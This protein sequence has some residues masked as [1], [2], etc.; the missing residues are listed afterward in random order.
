MVYTEIKEKN[1][2]KY[3]YRVKSIRKGNKVNKKRIY[4]GTNLKRKELK[5]KES[6]ADVEL[7]FLNNLLNKEETSFLKKIQRSY[8]NEPHKTIENRYEHF[9]ALFTYNSTAIEGNTFTL[10][11]TAHLLFDNMVPSSKSLREINEILNHKKAFDFLLNY[12]G[13]ISSKIICKLHSLVVQ[14]TLKPELKSQIGGYRTVQVFIRG[15]EFLPA[16]PSEVAKEMKSLILRYS[17]YKKDLH[18]L[19]LA[20]YFHIVFEIIH[21]F[22]DGNGRV[23]RLL[24]NFILHKNNYPMINIPNSIKIDYYK[25]L[26]EAQIRNNF[27]PFIELLLKILR[28]N[29]IIF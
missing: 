20:S 8:L 23:G 25:A 5:L 24:M 28:E 2:R 22:V 19:V 7:V 26:E 11:D 18:P 10:Q 6:K 15:V 13:D 12:K 16:K 4:L 3:Y 17:K 21:P 1:G 27:R 14:N 9:C 29:A